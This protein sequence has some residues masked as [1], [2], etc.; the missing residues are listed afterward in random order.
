M[1]YLLFLLTGNFGVGIASFFVFARL[2]IALNM[3]L[4]VLWTCVVIIP[5]AIAY[6]PSDIVTAGVNKTVNIDSGF[7]VKNLFDGRV[8]LCTDIY[9]GDWKQ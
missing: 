3:V 5:V 6:D 8:S 1:I 2:V 7:H 4:A 9:K